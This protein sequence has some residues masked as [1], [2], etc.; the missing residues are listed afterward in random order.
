M[1]SYSVFLKTKNDYY[2]KLNLDKIS[3]RKNN[4]MK[5]ELK[6][7]L[8][9]KFALYSEIERNYEIKKNNSSLKDRLLKINNRELK[10]EENKFVT[11]KLQFSQ[12]VRKIESQKLKD[13]NIYIFRRIFEQYNFNLEKLL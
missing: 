1:D 3:T 5:D 9:P 2:L 4:Y 13:Q 7:M 6:T 8:K 10:L 12:S 11:R